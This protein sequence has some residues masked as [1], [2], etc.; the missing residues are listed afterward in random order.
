MQRSDRATLGQYHFGKFEALFFLLHLVPHVREHKQV[1]A[2]A[3]YARF[4]CYFGLF[5]VAQVARARRARRAVGQARRCR[6]AAGRRYG[7][8]RDRVVFVHHVLLGQRLLD[9]DVLYKTIF[10]GL[11]GCFDF[12][13]RL[14]F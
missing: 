13:Q 4:H 8:R 2:R 12:P 10:A 5:L 11:F 14:V 6:R 9:F 7:R 3:E 1:L